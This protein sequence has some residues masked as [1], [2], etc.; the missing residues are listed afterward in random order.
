M[1]KIYL[2]DLIYDTVKSNFTVPLNIGYLAAFLKS[3]FSENEISVTLFKYPSELEEAL[4]NETPDILAFSNYSWNENLNMLF[5]EKAKEKNILTVMGGPNIRSDNEGIK[6]FL[7]KRKCLDYYVMFEGEEIF[8][9]LVENIMGGQKNVSIPGIARLGR[10]EL[11]Y[12]P[13]ELK[14]KP[15]EINFPSPYLS[16]ILD[17]FLQD[18]NFIPLLETNRGCPFGC[19]YCAWGISA[20]SKVRVR[21]I[22]MVYAE[23]D[24]IAE[25]SAGQVNWIFCDANFG[26]LKRDVEIAGKIRTVMDS[27][28]FPINVTVWNSKN[29]SERNLEIA[30]L[31]DPKK[32]S[33]LIAIQS[34]DPEV[35]KNAGRGM[36]DI[37]KSK[38][39]I[40]H[41]KKNG[42]TIRTDILLG[43]PGESSKSHL[44]TLCK[45][46]DMGFDYIQ[47]LNIRLLPGSEY[48]TG[49]YR[50]KYQVKTKFRPIFGAYGVYFGKKVFEMEESVRATSEISEEELNEFKVLHWLIF[51]IWNMGV[52]KPLLS[53]GYKNGLNPAMAMYK[54][55]RSANPVLAEFFSG[56]KKDS[57]NEW[58]ES[59]E[60]M[61]KFYNDDNNF[62][63]MVSNFSKL[64]FLYLG[65]VFSKPE[66]IKA[67]EDEI[68]DILRKELKTGEKIFEII[69]EL[70]GLSENLICRNLM[71]D[72]FEKI[73]ECSGDAASIVIRR[74][75]LASKEKVSISISRPESYVKFTRHHLLNN[76]EED[77]SLK[78]LARFFEIGGIKTI[79]NEVNIIA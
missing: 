52:L 6:E 67:M 20:L 2:A 58:F 56:I 48:E 27:K 38:I 45:A 74:P 72:K 70:A 41:H 21:D 76:G 14:G 63:D 7:S 15:K 78:N 40:E 71:E 44:G 65:L 77:L 17:K 62:N 68:L 53:F 42:L 16:G 39:E 59:R 18:K 22:D 57:M 5:L 64:N 54:L 46:F 73:L 33:V 19:V 60:E 8:G 36:I 29:T 50:E 43:L 49:A 34:A 9:S 30:E 69:N 61:E 51:F 47:P 28:G 31:L 23:I 13:A 79:K 37:E 10:G 12:T 25:K 66:V 1:F 26:I 11:F 35:L 24:Y 75:E 4:K 55:S 32:N 3:R